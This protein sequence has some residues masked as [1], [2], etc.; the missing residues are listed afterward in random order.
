M[1]SHG[2]PRHV[3]L[4][5]F[6]SCKFI[7]CGKINSK[8]GLF[9]SV[10]FSFTLNLYLKCFILSDLRANIHE[11]LLEI[12]FSR[13]KDPGKIRDSNI[14]NLQGSLLVHLLFLMQFLYFVFQT[15]QMK[16]TARVRH[17]KQSAN[18]LKQTETLWLI[19]Y[20]IYRSMSP[21]YS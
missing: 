5:I 19:L 17:T 4:I 12:F 14:Q 9:F 7:Y 8:P 3:C 2:L 20:Y 6:S 15:R 1:V 10:F 16:M 13:G 11:G 18:S 21:N